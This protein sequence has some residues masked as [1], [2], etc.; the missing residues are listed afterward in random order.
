MVH[1]NRLLSGLLAVVATA[2][3]SVATAQDFTEPSRFRFSGFGTFGLMQIDRSNIQYGLTGLED[4][5]VKNRLSP[6]FGSNLGLQGVYQVDRTFSITGQAVGYRT[7]DIFEPTLQWLFV[8]WQP[9][10]GLSL[11][12]GRLGSSTYLV[13]DYRLVNYAN[14][15]VR[16]PVDLYSQVPFT[17]IDGIDGT[18]RLNVGDT[19]LAAQA[20]YGGT[21]IH[22]GSS[23][24][25]KMRNLRGL[26]L[27][28]E[29]GPVT[30]RGGYTQTSL[31]A[32]P[33]GFDP[34]VTGLRGVAVFPGLSGLNAVADDFDL[35]ISKK[36]TFATLA[37]NVDYKNFIAIGEIGQRKIAGLALPDTT[38]WALTAGYRIGKF[39]PY[40]MHSRVKIDSPHSDSRVPA[41]GPT[42]PLNAGV[43]GTLDVA[44][45]RTSSAGI[46]WDVRDNMALKFQ[47]D[48]SRADRATASGR[49]GTFLNPS[50]GFDSAVNVYSLN[51][52]F[53][54]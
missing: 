34:L 14:L 12:G 37:A 47:I 44:G 36:A 31:R 20:Y 18:Y 49:F 32:S 38:A 50:P 9:L 52:D 24:G 16:P 3:A 29:K 41:V 15:W 40:L 53:V 23:T 51:L 45:A 42:A 25:A 39:T 54:F 7:S 4:K 33:S 11:R 30:I 1:R 17:N 19:T 48:H 26:T 10:N 46:R 27:S 43:N 6:E 13:S 35:S 5:G 22:I 8:K 28:V 21:I 2:C